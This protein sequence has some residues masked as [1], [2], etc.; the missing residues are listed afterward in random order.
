MPMKRSNPQ[1]FLLIR[2]GFSSF[3]SLDSNCALNYKSL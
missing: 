1:R 3:F 2:A